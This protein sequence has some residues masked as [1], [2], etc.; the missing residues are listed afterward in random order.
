MPRL[1]LLTE[2]TCL[3]VRGADAATFLH[4]QLSQTIVPGAAT[5]APLAGWLDA[6]GRVRALLR[7]WPLPDRWLLGT[8]RDG[9]DD[10]LKRLRMFVLRSAVTLRVA[11]EVALAAL[12][13]PTPDWL[14]AHGLAPG[15]EPGAVIPSGDLHWLCVGAGYWQVLGPRGAV[16]AFAPDLARV[17]PAAAALAEIR[18]GLPAIT[19]PLVDRFVA[20]MLNLDTLG[21]T[22]FDKGCYPGQEIVA[23]VHN[24]GD[25]KRR[26]HRYST[27]AAPPG[28]GVAVTA[29]GGNV[30]GEVVRSA[31]TPTG[32]ELLAVVDHAVADGALAI[33]GAALH[34]LPLPFAVPR[35]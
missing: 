3:E 24:L 18:L 33:E 1:S 8:P 34:E 9:V 10:L 11:D 23:R 26:V 35:R 32:C 28:I 20:Q 2:S 14:A 31:P 12:L 21:A 22:A 17:P 30:V 16:E 5:S 15:A 27:T 29:A 25:V 13:D 7:V 19:P 6:R 4:A